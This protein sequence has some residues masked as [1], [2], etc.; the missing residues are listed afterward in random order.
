MLPGIV[1]GYGDDILLLTGSSSIHNAGHGEDI[2]NGL[3]DIG[4]RIFHEIISHEP[5][6]EIVDR[7]VSGYKSKAIKVVVAVGGGSVMDAGK[8]VSA[9]LHME[10]GIKHYLEGIG[11]MEHPGIK[12][13]FIA[14]PTTSGTGRGPK[15]IVK[16]TVVDW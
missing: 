7:I 15:D 2:Q 1:K 9:M 10:H 16:Y 14:M 13:P 3:K 5:S 11:D 12:V 8:A 4:A 6:P